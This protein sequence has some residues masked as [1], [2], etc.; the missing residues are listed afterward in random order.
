MCDNDNDFLLWASD[1]P[2]EIAEAVTSAGFPSTLNADNIWQI[3]AGNTE[4]HDPVCFT[5]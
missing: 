3:W 5:L 2:D 1:A 4:I